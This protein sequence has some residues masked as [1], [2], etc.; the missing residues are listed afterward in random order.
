MPEPP[1][2]SQVT[3]GNNMTL[4]SYKPNKIIED[5]LMK[6]LFTKV[7]AWLRKTNME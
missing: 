2:I 5:N 7:W 3:E 1:V 6:G 4:L